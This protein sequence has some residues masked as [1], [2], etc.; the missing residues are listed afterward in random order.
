[1][2]AAQRAGMGREG[3]IVLH[4]TLIEAGVGQAALIIALAEPASRIAE[5]GG[6]DQKRSVR[7]GFKPGFERRQRRKGHKSSDTG[8]G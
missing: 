6:R 4:E 7:Q 1:M 3:Q 5:S 2:Q 8:L